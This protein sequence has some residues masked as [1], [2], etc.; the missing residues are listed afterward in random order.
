MNS[1]S[2]QDNRR[3]AKMIYPG[4]QLL[5]G[6]LYMDR[7]KT[8]VNVMTGDHLTR[9]QYKTIRSF[10]NTS[11]VIIQY[12]N[13]VITLCNPNGQQLMN[14]PLDSTI[15]ALY[16]V[17]YTSEDGKESY[18]IFK[19]KYDYAELIIFNEVEQR[20]KK[21]IHPISHYSIHGNNL[22]I[23]YFSSDESAETLKFKI[24]MEEI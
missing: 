13:D 1:E 4:L 7:N 11:I 8:L 14:I 5:K 22:L 18:F 17:G 3:I 15:R 24:K 6:N 21:H 2:K 9:D 12:R 20:I 19:R 16:P 23:Y 10:T